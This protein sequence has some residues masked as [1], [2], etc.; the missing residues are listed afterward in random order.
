[1]LDAALAGRNWLVGDKLSYA[2][3]RVASALPFAA[4]AGLPLAEFPNVDRWHDRL[5]ALEA[6][7]APF[8][9]LA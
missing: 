8:E 3:F 4:G 2:D 9:G 7:R 5:L 6:W 1:V